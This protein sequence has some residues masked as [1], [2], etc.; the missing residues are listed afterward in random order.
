MSIVGSPSL[1][2]SFP[3]P[4]SS[5]TAAVELFH[6]NTLSTGSRMEEGSPL[7]DHVV[8]LGQWEHSLERPLV[9]LWKAEQQRPHGEE[10]EGGK[11]GGDQT[12]GLGERNRSKEEDKG[13]VK[14]F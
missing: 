9:E 7:E 6:L 5:P 10:K 3:A 11:E 14:L 13:K 8:G 1:P 2:L 4:R 12:F